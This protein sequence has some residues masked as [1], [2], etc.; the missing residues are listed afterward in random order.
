MEDE[1]S[2]DQPVVD[3]PLRLNTSLVCL[4]VTGSS[5]ESY[6]LIT[7]SRL[8]TTGCGLERV[9]TVQIS[10]IP[11]TSLDVENFMNSCSVSTDNNKVVK[12]DDLLGEDIRD[13]LR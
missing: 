3:K 6:F 5:T 12:V 2:R 10:L 8:R 9:T 1:A 4:L 13:A 11:T 7:P